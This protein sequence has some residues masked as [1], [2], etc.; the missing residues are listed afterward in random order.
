VLFAI[1]AFLGEHYSD[2]SIRGVYFEEVLA[3]KVVVCEEGGLSEYI[4][5]C[6]K[7]LDTLIIKGELVVYLYKLSK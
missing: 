5:E 3:V 2:N 7:H 4:I 1:K 6:L